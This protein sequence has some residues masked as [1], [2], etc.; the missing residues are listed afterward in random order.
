MMSPLL[1]D[2]LDFVRP[3]CS[4][5]ES[6]LG[7]TRALVLDNGIFTLSLLPEY[8]GRLCSLFYRPLNVELLATEFLHG[9]RKSMNVHGGW[10]AAFPSLLADGEQLS[11][12]SWEADI[13]EQ[14]D[15]R[16]TAHLWCHIER[17]SHQLDGQTRVTPGM[18]LV[19]RFVRLQA[20]ES[21]VVVEDVLTNRNVWPVPVTWS[22]VVSLR[23]R[24]G[25][26][27]IFPVDTLE[28]QRGVGP[29][30]SELDFGL[31]VTTPYQAMARNL[32][33]GW[34]GFCPAWAPLDIQ[35]TFPESLLPHAVVFAQRDEAHHAE[36]LVRLQP[37][38]TAGPIADD[39]R[40]G[41][42]VLPPKRPVSI[43]VRL[44]AGANVFVAGEGSRPGLQLAGL[45]TEQRV[46]AGRMGIWRVGE[47]T[48]VLKT[49]HVLALV[50][51]DFSGDAVMQCD[52]LPAADLILFGEEPP[53]TILRRLV[54]RT[55]ARFVGPAGIRQML[56]TDGVDSERAVALS[57]GARFDLPG[58]GVLATPARTEENRDGLGFLVQ[59]EHLSLYCAGRTQFLGEFGPIGEQ[60][61][62][63]LVLLALSGD[64]TL[65]DSV[66]A[67]KLLQPRLTVPLGAGSEEQDF[68]KRCRDQ[69]MSFAAEALG[70]AE[71]RL[72]D[73]W[74]LLPL[75]LT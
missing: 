72:F 29:S 8:G 2:N 75:A 49:P 46:P 51:P 36:G 3:R 40:G 4:A 44:D 27:A 6:T 50:M 57:P 74:H 55:S 52:D 24:A 38:A 59:S 62:P 17:V 22:G 60:F 7:D 32:R 47:R 25:D 14:S 45:I 26:R 28:V 21:A 15:E 58:L 67:A 41:A 13:S 64:L 63:Q 23:A 39:T 42:L 43:P 30:G 37:L 70:P 1:P 31:L 61:H 11:H 20:G 33:R 54:Q 5:R 56:I 19:E 48:V 69:H 9:P 53:R 71:G 34:L 10:C 12:Q 65:S 66:H 68:I 16:V 18:I 35:L 73:G